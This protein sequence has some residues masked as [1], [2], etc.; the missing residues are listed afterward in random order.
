MK[1]PKYIT[2]NDNKFLNKIRYNLDAEDRVELDKLTEKLLVLLNNYSR[3]KEKT[4]SR[5]MDIRKYDKLYARSK[6]DI[7][8][9]FEVQVVKIK[10]ALENKN[11]NNARELYAKMK[12]AVCGDRY[13][14]YYNDAIE[15]LSQEEINFLEGVML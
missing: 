9:Y 14:N 2:N 10:Q 1:Q 7:K 8:K 4:S 11:S 5:I 3:Y 12:E 6:N 13:I 15:Q